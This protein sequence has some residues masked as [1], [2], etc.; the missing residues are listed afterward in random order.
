MSAIVVASVLHGAQ[1]AASIAD[2]G[3]PNRVVV[4]R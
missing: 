4:A 3:L 2:A 1:I